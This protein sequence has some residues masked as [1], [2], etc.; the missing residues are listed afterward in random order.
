MSSIQIST[1]SPLLS[2][3]TSLVPLPAWSTCKPF[4]NGAVAG[5]MTTCILQPVDMI[6]VSIQSGVKGGPLQIAANI[7]KTDGVRALYK[8]LDAGLLRQATY[9]NARM[10]IYANLCSVLREGN[11]G[12]A[13]PLWQKAMA[14][15]AAGGLGAIIGNPADLTLVRMQADRTLPPEQRR[16]YRSIGDAFTRIVREEGVRGLFRGAAPTATRAMALNMGMLA[17]NDQ[18]K[19]MLSSLGAGKQTSVLGGAFLA[20]FIASAC[21]LPFDSVKTK[22]LRQQRLPDGSLPFKGPLDCAR[23]ILISEGPLAFYKG[24]P[25]YT[26]RV[27]PQVTFTLMFMDLLPK[28]QQPFGL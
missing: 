28:L 23:K 8:G 12:N 1:P 13:I 20:G 24:L 14:G 15:C 9:T 22:M 27:A 17:A 4:F 18:A 11:G 3:T 21:S 16:N 7:I 10:G 19:E 26:A 25:T 5:C 6:K 2:N